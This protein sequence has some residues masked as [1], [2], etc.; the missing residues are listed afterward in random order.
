VAFSFVL[1]IGA[2]LLTRSLM[3][4][5]RVDPGFERQNVV[6]AGVHLICPRYTTAGDWRGV[7]ARL[8]E[9][10][11]EQPETDIA[12]VSSGFPLD[13]DAATYGAWNGRFDI[14]GGPS[15][16]TAA[17]RVVTPG[18]FDTLGV[19]ILDGR[20]FGEADDQHAPA[21]AIVSQSFARRSWGAARAVGKTLT[22][23]DGGRVTVIGVAGDVKEFG[24]NRETPDEIYGPA[25]QRPEFVSAVLI[26]SAG[27]P[28][29]AATAVR[30]AIREADPEIAITRVETLSQASNDSL[31]LHRMT[32]RLIALF[33][34]L[35]LVIAVF[36]VGA[37]LSLSVRRRANEIAVRLAM[38]ARASTVLGSLMRQGMIQVAIGVILG[39]AGAS[40]LTGSLRGLLFEVAPTDPTTFLGTTFALVVAG[41]LACYAPAARAVRVDPLRVLKSE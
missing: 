3:N 2:G 28:V 37:A 23:G 40:L 34:V 27:D 29:V 8:L 19:P 32:A 38:G 39:W 10:L 36:G 16:V 13:P 41:L 20:E 1:L 18:Y 4:L 5:R 30:R 6:A 12:A 7:T 35:A 22:L 17:M 9:K 14:D 33:A 24:L 11:R 21:V 26:R 25:A 15:G 31:A